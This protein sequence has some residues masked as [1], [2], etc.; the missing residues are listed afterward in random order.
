MAGNIK[1]TNNASGTLAA[2]IAA[3]DVSIT[4]SAGQ[5]NLFPS[6]IG[7]QYAMCTLESSAGVLEIVKMTARAGDVLTVVR[8]QEGTAAAAFASGSRCELRLT[9]AELGEFVQRAADTLNGTY[10]CTAGV[11][12]GAS[13]RNGEVVNSPVRGDPGVTTNQFVVPPGGGPPTIGGSLVYTAANLTAAIVNALIF[14]V[15]TVLMF[16]GLIGNIPVGFQLCDGTNGTLDLRGRFIVGAG[17]AYAVGATGGAASVVSG[18]GGAHTHTIQGTAI[19]I[20]QMPAHAHLMGS[21]G[22][23]ASNQ[24][25]TQQDFI[26]SYG[27]P[28]ATLNTALSE[29]VGGGATHT[30]VADAVA[31]HTHTVTTLPPYAGLFFIQKV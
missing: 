12:T 31:D 17:G 30:H 5:G 28:S 20:A 1:F 6:P 29:T 2:G 15:G 24:G 10:D 21:R 16:N 9:A 8:A 11:F 22:S 26:R 14:P 23:N 4:L 19:T 27:D 25:N 18:A 13:N 3:G 7:S